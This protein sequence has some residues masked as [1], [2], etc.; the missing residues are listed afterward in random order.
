MTHG[1]WQSVHEGGV[2][3]E[4]GNVWSGQVVVQEEVFVVELVELSVLLVES[5]IKNE[6]LAHDKQL[7]ASS[8][9]VWQ[10]TSH[11][12][13]TKLESKVPSGHASKHWLL[14]RNTWVVIFNAWS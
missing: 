5:P 3:K 6:L 7:V 12:K 1:A 2:L 4:L 14:N 10:F 13:H 11:D 9:Q 8:I